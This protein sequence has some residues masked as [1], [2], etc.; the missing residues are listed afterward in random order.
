[1]GRRRDGRVGGREPRG[2]VCALYSSHEFDEVGFV[3][4]A[5]L[6]GVGG[7]HHGAQSEAAADLESLLQ[8][9]LGD[10]SGVVRV[11][12]I[13]ELADGGIRE[14]VVKVQFLVEIFALPLQIAPS[15]QN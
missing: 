6:V 12:V 5:V 8:V 4:H 11:K 1:M 2:V 15:S 7:G 14:R 3:D 13:K 9:R 10:C